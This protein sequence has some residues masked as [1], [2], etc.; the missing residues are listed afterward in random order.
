MLIQSK[1]LICLRI[2]GVISRDIDLMI[3]KMYLQNGTQFHGVEYIGSNEE[4]NLYKVI[5]VLKIAGLNK[6]IPYC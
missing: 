2:K 1:L 5:V 4:G 3:D 6:S